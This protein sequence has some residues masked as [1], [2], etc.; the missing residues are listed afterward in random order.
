MTYILKAFAVN[1]NFINNTPGTVAPFGELSP[2]SLT[3]SQEVGVYTASGIASLSLVSFTS[4]S[5]GANVALTTIDAQLP[6]RILTIV[7]WIY[8]QTTALSGAIYADQLLSQLLVNFNTTANT[9]DC[10]SIIQS[11]LAAGT[12]YIPEW[13][14]WVD[15]ATGAVIKIWFVD[16]SFQTEYDDYTIV[17][18]P[19]FTPVSNFFTGASKVQQYL[20]AV[21]YIDAIAN[22]ETAKNGKSP[23]ITTAETFSYIDPTNSANT[24]A[25]NWTVLI[26]GPQGNSV[27]SISDAL[28]TYCIDNSSYTQ[29]QWAAILPDIFLRTEFVLVPFWDQ[30]AI[31]DGS[32]Q[33]GIYS[34]Q[35]NVARG[36]A[37]METV[38]ASYASSHIDTYWNV[39]SFPYRSLQLGVIGSANN[40]NAWYELIDVFPDIIT[41]TS[42]S[43]DFSRMAVA[44]QTFLESLQTMLITAETM[45][46]TSTIPSGYTRVTRDNKLYIVLNYDNI[47]YLVLAKAGLTTVITGVT[48]S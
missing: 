14:S 7:Q 29:A 25:T 2:Y 12:Y 18:V 3:F 31:P 27:D 13:V 35:L 38:V 16:A 42:T 20:N 4:Q 47:H 37:L 19:P 26:Y 48:S 46:S 44:T 15:V 22:I 45:T 28:V 5:N 34:P 11:T 40:K 36:Q 9:F 32:N 21:T 24:I 23:T 33:D 6:T 41:V 43:T 10:G 17:V 30:Y 39:M 8:A 1:A